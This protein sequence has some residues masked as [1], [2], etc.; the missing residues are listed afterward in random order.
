MRLSSSRDRTPPSRSTASSRVRN[1][2]N[3]RARPLHNLEGDLCEILCD[4]ARNVQ[5]RFCGPPG[6]KSSLQHSYMYCE[7]RDL[8]GRERVAAVGRL[9]PGDGASAVACTGHRR[10][11]ASIGHGRQSTSF[12]TSGGGMQQQNDSNGGSQQENN[13]KISSDASLRQRLAYRFER[14]C[15]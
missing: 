15:Q 12:R 6:R 13:S 5:R 14:P 4:L 11:V 10:R 9:P 2:C 3:A 8:L 7:G 1:P